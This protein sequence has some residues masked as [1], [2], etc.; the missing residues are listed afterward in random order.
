MAL[1]LGHDQACGSA[2][3][4]RLR[5]GEPVLVKSV[6]SVSLL[7]ILPVITGAQSPGT[8]A[9]PR[10][11]WGDPDLQGIWSFAILTPME[12]P[13]ELAGKDVLTEEEAA[14]YEQRD[15]EIR[16]RPNPATLE[17][18]CPDDFPF[19]SQAPLAYEFRIWLD[20]GTTV[21]STRRTSLV[22]DPPDGRIPSL[23]PE[24]EKRRV[25]ARAVSLLAAGPED[26]SLVDRCIV[27]F[28]AGPPMT[29]G[30]YLNHVQVFQSPGYVALL[31]EMGDARIVPMDGGPHGTL[32]QWAG[33][34]RGRWE[35]NTLVVDTTNARVFMRSRSS[36]T[37]HL[38]ERFT[39]VNADSLL[40][41][42][43]VEDPTTWTRPW[44]FEVPMMSS[45]GPL[46]EYACHEGNYAMANILSAARAQEK[47]A[48][49]DA[50]QGSR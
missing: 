8:A 15:A 6:I 33:D 24:V 7:V 34:S 50:R 43:T 22:V 35:G 36:A 18:E 46:Y 3:H 12:R 31:P 19:C 41:E 38:V 9:V 32:R 13:A 27:G 26:R 10:T 39:R 37:L 49:E 11:A 17:D 16:S 44:T 47:V 14:A 40:Y 42:V 45:E 28:N 4:K 48:E 21:A 30:P 29:P 2:W 1:T 5:K 25:A 23:T 20:R